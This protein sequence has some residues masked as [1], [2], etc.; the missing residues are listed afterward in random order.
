VRDDPEDW[1]AIDSAKMGGTDI[2][3]RTTLDKAT[4]QVRKRS[5]SQGPMQIDFSVKDGKASGELKAS[6]Q[7]RP[8]AVDLGGE[9]FG[10]GAGAYQVIATLPFA[11]GYKTAFRNFDV[12]AQKARVVQLEVAGS[13]QVTV[14]AGTFDAYKIEL[15]S[16]EDGGKTTVWV[17][18]DSRK[19]VKFVGV[20]PRMQG[21]T[22][23]TELQK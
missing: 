9:L 14:P 10:D 20:R 3:D 1:V 22:I 23:T 8:I 2:A 6:G 7:T 13:E 16:A 15:S 12:Q 4:L 19:V 17:A 18:K 5:I 11:P 21:A